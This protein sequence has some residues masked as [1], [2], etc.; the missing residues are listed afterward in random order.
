MQSKARVGKQQEE[1]QH[2]TNKL[3]SNHDTKIQI[4]FLKGII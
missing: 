3:P 4:K 2:K 1:S